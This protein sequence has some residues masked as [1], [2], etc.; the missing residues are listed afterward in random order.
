MKKSLSAKDEVESKQIEAIRELS[1]AN[2]KWEE[3]NKKMASDLV[4]IL[5]LR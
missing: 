2:T 5:S 4:I 1:S 3:V